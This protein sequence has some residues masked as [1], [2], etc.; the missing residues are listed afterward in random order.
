MM[1]WSIFRSMQTSFGEVVSVLTLA[2]CDFSSTF[3][4]AFSFRPVI[5]VDQL[6]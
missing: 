6:S 4:I 5:T 2:A 1:A 3:F